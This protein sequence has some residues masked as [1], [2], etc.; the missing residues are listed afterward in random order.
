MM[1]KGCWNIAAR[2]VEMI[3]K[4]FLS[5]ALLTPASP[6]L[7]FSLKIQWIKYHKDYTIYELSRCK[8]NARVFLNA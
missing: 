7:L 6:L 4:T 8:Y 2:Q 5:L 1:V 3:N